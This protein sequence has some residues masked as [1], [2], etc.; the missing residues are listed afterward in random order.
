[1]VTEAQ[2]RARLDALAKPR[3]SLGRME[4]LAARLAALQ[5]T[6]Q[7]VT[8]PRVLVLFAADHGVVASGVSAWPPAVTALMARTITDGR[9]VSAAWAKLHDCT[10]RLVDMGIGR[11]THDL[12]RQPAMSAAQFDAAWA[13]GAAEARAALGAGSRLLLAGEMGIGNT[14][15]AAC[16]V[17]LLS[18]VAPAQATGRGAGVDD[19]AFA[20]KQRIVAQAV[21]RART[22]LPRDVRAAIAAVC[23]FEIAAMAGFFAE[24]AARSAVVVLDGFVATAAALVAERLRPGTAACLVAS[25]LSAEQG[26]AAALATLG[27]T[28]LLAW[29]MR[30]GEGSGALLAL[31]LLDSAAALLRDVARLD[32]LGVA[33]GD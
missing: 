4:T 26:H 8:R 3:G 17:A 22:R 19:P 10:L 33:R 5:G 25:H 21:A 7:P 14:T 9:S 2:A 27:L 6:L 11:P 23:G 31:P 12:S 30:L 29:E 16:L 1:M 15:A 24:G 18:E 32:E 28:P 13:R 20:V